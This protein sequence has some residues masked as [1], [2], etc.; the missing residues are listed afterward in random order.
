M[1]P[2]ERTYYN[3]KR[4]HAIFLISSLML[5]AVTGWMLWADHQRPWKVYQRTFRDRIEP[6]MISTPSPNAAKESPGMPPVKTL[7]RPLAIDQIWLPE[8]TIDYHFRQVA[9]FDR[10]VTCH[11]GID[12]TQADRQTDRQTDA[13]FGVVRQQLPSPAR[14]RGA[15]G[16]GVSQQDTESLPDGRLHPAE[17]PHIGGELPQPYAA[18]PRPELYV[19]SH[20]PHPMGRFGCTICHDGQGSATDFGWASHAPNDPPQQD[21][22][23]RQYDWSRNPYW[24]YPMLPSR[25]A[26]SRCLKCH[27]EVSDL[28]PSR[29]FPDPPAAKL[30]AGYQLV[31][32]LGCFGCHEIK[33]I[34]ESGRSVGP[35]MRLEPAGGGTAVA[36]AHPGTMRKVGPS[37]RDIGSKVEAAFLADWIR[38][39]THFLSE[40]RMPRSYGLQEHLQGRSLA[41]ARRFEAV[42]IQALTAYLLSASQPVEPSAALEATEAPSAERGKRLFEIRGCLACH[43]HSDFPSRRAPGK[44][45]QGPDLSQVG[46]KFTSPAGAQWLTDW[47]RDPSRHSPRTLMPKIPLGPEP[48]RG[49]PATEP[50]PPQ[51]AGAVAA[52]RI[53]PAADIAAFLLASQGDYR[54]LPTSDLVASDLDELVLMYLKGSFPDSEARQVVGRGIPQAMAERVRGDAAE[55]LGEPT[56]LKKLRYVGLRTLRRRGCVACHDIPGLEDAQQIGLAMSDWGRKPESLLLFAEVRRLVEQQPAERGGQTPRDSGSSANSSVDP[57][58]VLDRAEG[59]DLVRGFFLDALQQQRREGFLWQKLRAPRSFDFQMA[60]N[61]A[62]NQWLTMPQFQLS[63]SQREAIMTFVLGLVAQPPAEQYVYAPGA[64]DRAIVEGRKVLDKYACATC[65]LLEMERW[66]FKFDPK[67]FQRPP[68]TAG[69][70]ALQSTVSPQQLAAS[71]ETDNRELCTAEVVGMPRVDAAGALVE[72]EDDDGNP[73]Y[74]FALWEPAAIGGQIVRPGGAEVMISRP[75]LVTQ[76]PP[77]GGDLARLLFPVVLSQARA[78][79][80]AAAEQEAWGWLPP[81]LVGEGAKVQPAWLHDYLLRPTPIRPAAVLRMPQFNLSPAE[82]GKLVDY[83][84]AMSGANFPYASPPAETAA[85]LAQR[86]RRLPG[87]L[88]HAMKILV[89]RTTFCAKCHLIGD[90]EPGGEIRTTLAPNLEQVGRRI[91]PEYVG[92]WLANPKAALPYTPMPVNFPPTGEPLGQDLFPGSSVEQRDAVTDL[93]LNY[94]RY[95]M[96]RISIRQNIRPPLGDGLSPGAENR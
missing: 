34:D 56:L 61:T 70:D 26:E 11:Q 24:E 45:A 96:G 76:H 71:A 12:R 35:D 68:Q 84:A 7:G 9:R 49:G 46:A 83:F 91:R 72:D 75:Q 60:Q 16:E 92:R 28:A 94:D 87:R 74:F 64:R 37:L 29:K 32:R 27:H 20:S 86:Q 59:D 65:H 17:S 21:R 89:D 78:A 2:T 38:D 88:D 6:L 31:R 41:D 82:A 93:L 63:P 5:L 36:G 25:F 81:P 53:D 67:T 73:L 43:G 55:L 58:T 79:G 40:A 10:C 51:A 47:I 39:P 50:L 69:D 44:V 66:T 23:R 13:A 57:T 19:G 1:P 14:G 52:A 95:I 30:S 3:M 4:L 90:Y 15:G 77:R 8:L 33:G 22:W 85:E 42:E 80:S 18:H 48:W 54:P 62:Y